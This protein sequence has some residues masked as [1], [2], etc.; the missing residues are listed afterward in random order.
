MMYL[1]LT[2]G[3]YMQC[4]C[5]RLNSLREKAQKKNE[6]LLLREQ[7]KEMDKTLSQKID[8][9]DYSKAFTDELLELKQ[10]EKDVF[11][12]MHILKEGKLE[13]SFLKEH[14]GNKINPDDLTQLYDSI[15]DERKYIRNKSLA[16]IYSLFGI[17]INMIANFLFL[18]KR[19]IKKQIAKFYRQGVKKYLNSHKKEMRVFDNTEIQNAVFSNLHNPP[20]LHGINRTTWTV[21][22]IQKVV[23]KQGYKVGRNSVDKIIKNA[24]Y[25]FRKAREVL[26]SK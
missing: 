25:R 22:L 24:G 16:V 12:F 15:F 8:Q 7:L 11:I 6:N 17:H 3:V 5:K 20:I 13:F 9:Y 1:Y 18:Y 2:Q 23:N 14:L 4:S 10:L 26:T 19:T 21:K